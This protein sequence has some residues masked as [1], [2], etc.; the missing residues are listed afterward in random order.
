MMWNQGEGLT[1]KSAPAIASIKWAPAAQQIKIHNGQVYIRKLRQLMAVSARDPSTCIRIL[2][3]CRR[4]WSINVLTMAKSSSVYAEPTYHPPYAW[5]ALP[6]L[7]S[8]Q[9]RARTWPWVAHG[10]QFGS[11]A[12]LKQFYSGRE[13]ILLRS[14]IPDVNKCDRQGRNGAFVTKGKIAVPDPLPYIIIP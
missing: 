11:G 13:G 2:L 6:F 12:S 3:V 14:A 7:L 4:T 10:G 5:T 9:R 1:S 8:E